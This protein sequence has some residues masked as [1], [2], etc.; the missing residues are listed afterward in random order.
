MAED[1]AQAAMPVT[2]DSPA[3]ASHGD[4]SQPSVAM[5]P[6][7][8]QDSPLSPRIHTPN[9]FSRHNTSLDLDDYFVSYD[10]RHAATGHV[11]DRWGFRK[12]PVTFNG[13][14]NGPYF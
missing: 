9:P 7:A 12:D 11:P 14:R 2:T 1:G 5:P 6:L 3:H 4:T 8:Q 13:I 10:I